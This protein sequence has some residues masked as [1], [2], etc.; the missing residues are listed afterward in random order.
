MRFAFC[1]ALACLC[2]G[3]VL[4]GQELSQ[5]SGFL[6]DSSGALIPGADLTVVGE[7]TG[8]RRVTTSGTAG[9]Y[10]VAY[11]QPGRYK[12]TVHREGFRTLVR[13]GLKLDAGQG[14]RADF[15]LELG[16][17]NDVITVRDEPALLNTDDASIS[18]LVG[19][20]W[21][22]NLPLEGRGIQTLLELAPGVVATPASGGEAGQFT[23]NGQ[24]PNTNFFTVDGI[25]A[26]AG[27]SS[28]LPAQM[29][30]GSLPNMTAFGSLHSLAPVE[31]LDA[32]RVLTSTVTSE[33]GRS[34]GGQV[35]LSSRS[36]SNEFHGSILG[37]IRNQI[38][39]ANDW[40]ANSLNMPRQALR[41]E[42]V[43]V[44]AGGPIRRNRTF[45]FL[46]YEGLRL[47]QP[48]TWLTT[49]PSVSARQ[50]APAYLQPWLNAFPVPNGTDF[51]G[52]VAGWTGS[53]SH[54]ST[55]D[56]GTARIDHALTGKVLLFGRF[57]RTP[58][59]NEFGTS[60]IQTVQINSQSLTG[61]LNAELSRSAISELRVNQTVTRADSAWQSQGAMPAC[62]TASSC[63]SF[64]RFSIDGVGDFVAGGAAHNRQQQVSVIDSTQVRWFRHELRFGAEYR[65]LTL[66][67]DGP[68]AGMN[69]N[70]PSMLALL[71]GSFSISLWQAAQQT[72]TETELSAF[73]EDAW[74]VSPR[75]TLTG[76]VRWNFD[77]APHVPPP[78]IVSGAP[79][80]GSPSGVPIWNTSYANFAPHVGAA[81]RLT[82][83]G[84]T[85]LRSGWGLYYN[86]DFGAA[87]DGINGAP[88]NAWQFNAGGAAG[89]T[90]VLIT[91]GFAPNLRVPAT[92]QWNVSIERSLTSNDVL[93]AAYT[94]AFSGDLLR[95][96]VGAG[97]SAAAEIV[98]ATNHGQ[99]DYNALQVQYRRRLSKEWQAL[100]SYTW[101][102]SLD[103]G[104]ADSAIYWVSPAALTP[105]DR[106]SSDF[107]VRHTF[108]AAFSFLPSRYL[109]RWSIDG[110][111][112]A[113]TGFPVN[114]ID[115]ETALG[116]NFAN[117]FRP[118]LIPG[119][120]VWLNDSTV[121]AGRR[122]NPAAFSA[123]A[124]V[125]G[126]LGR[127]AISGF[128]TSQ[129]DLSIHRTFGLGEKSSL[130]AGAEA[131]N[132]LNQP[133]FADPERFLSS[134]LFGQATSMLNRMLGSGTPSTGLTPAFQAGGTRSVQIVLRFR[135]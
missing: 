9:G 48:F 92:Q 118:D 43:G 61:G 51:G 30:G 21:I 73:V 7:E 32:I 45:F 98:V 35:E 79:G 99:S 68:S 116:L 87:T 76:G 120:P 113:R 128:G 108:T 96:E 8:F 50:N 124:S 49:V 60:Q 10:Q 62:D 104:S 74:R 34:A 126:N 3:R 63:S 65:R 38:L 94:G 123:V 127:N 117:V 131:F 107:D 88:Y 27:V 130:D 56:G 69:I 84:R 16:S 109:R 134:P 119:E 101:G 121:P 58:S 112:H 4:T 64:Y 81:Y 70:A 75:L 13:F 111:L 25:S 22:E 78:L 93:M 2:G 39:D 12:V 46:S 54:P 36:G 95:R 6:W 44:T 132:I 1:L 57:T 15:H 114:V 47:S 90:P 71:N 55:F 14:L 91:Y 102:H 110:V 40:F 26:N 5:L 52:G 86:P 19:R 122:L 82:G 53:S 28:G 24:R 31:G 129:L 59:S 42:D 105:S 83:D 33:H 97:S 103:N 106:A 11:L 37:A 67:R 80:L 23:V 135:F 133:A 89:I 72:A 18:T 100:V 125:Q 115:S 85:V 66:D 20:G 29:P 41:F 77:P 17:A